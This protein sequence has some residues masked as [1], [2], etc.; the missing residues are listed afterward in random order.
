MSS[1]PQRTEVLIVGAGPA[2]TTLAYHLARLGVDVLL[3]DKAKF[4][5][6]KTCAGGVNVRVLGLLPFDLEPV[7]ERV[8]S[9]VTITRHLEK[10]FLRRYPEPIMVTV[11]RDSF[12]HFLAQRAKETGALFLDGIQFLSLIPQNGHVQVETSAGICKAK[13]VIGAD[14]PQSTV[15]RRLGLLRETHY[16]LTIHSEVP[17]YLLPWTEPDVIRIDW[18]SLKR[19]YAY[20]FPKRDFF[21]MGAGGFKIPPPAIKNYQRAFFATQWGKEEVPPFSAAGFILT[22]RRKRSPIHKGRC[23]LLGDAAGLLDPFTGEGIYSAV[24]SA[25]LAAP[26]VAEALKEKQESLSPC[27]ETIDRELMPELECSRIFREIFNFS[28]SFFHQKIASSDRW[29][30]AM[31]KILRGEKTFL[32]VKKHLGFLGSLL[33]RMAR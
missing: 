15:A 14:G 29:W 22:L 33:L 20:L 4:P 31:A 12:D 1:F 5:R 25:Q 32:D 18:G 7:V 21:S 3:L 23:L 19:S 17:S 8:I 6:Q 30:N 16:I 26:L 24:R 11:R 27:Q 2:G 13:F 9:G 10:P 28:P